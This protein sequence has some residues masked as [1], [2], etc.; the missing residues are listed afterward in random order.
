[1]IL[2]TLVLQG[3]TLPALIRRLA[4][5]D[6]GR[7]APEENDARL[8]AA[9]AA[10]DRLE[11]LAAEAWA[12]PEVIDDLRR[13]YTHRLRRL[14]VRSDGRPDG[15]HEERLQQSR[16]LRQEL[17]D[18]EH[19]TVIALRDQGVINDQVLHKIERDLDLD[20]V[21]RGRD[22]DRRV[23]EKNYFTSTDRVDKTLA[24]PSKAAVFTT[25][26]KQHEH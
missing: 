9:E 7:A 2:V 23:E 4:V 10:R 18:A 19:N 1:V 14:R 20:R 21:R 13:H 3:L 6:D 11:A 26:Q 22:R 25:R 5:R 24:Y 16:R 8:R 12:P 15:Q 17:V